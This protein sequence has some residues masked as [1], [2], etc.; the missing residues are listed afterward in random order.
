[1]RLLLDTHILQ[2]LTLRPERLSRAERRLIES[3]S[4]PLAVSAVSLWEMRIKW[5]AAHRSGERKGQADPE[6]V[7][8][9]LATLPIAYA[10]LALSFAHAVA[11]LRAPLDHDDPFDRLLLTQAQVEDLKLLTRD[12]RLEGH[13]LAVVA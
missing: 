2:W 5:Q 6:R 3:A 10:P 8:A 12:G 7:V 11:V 13:P 4:A 1:M 9:T